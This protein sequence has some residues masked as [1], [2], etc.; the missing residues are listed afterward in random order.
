MPSSKILVNGHT[1]T[2]FDRELSWLAFSRRLLYAVADSHQPIL[3]RVKQL[4]QAS[5]SLDE[6]FMVKVP[7]LEAAAPACDQRQNHPQVCFQSIVQALVSRQQAHFADTL[8]PHLA[9]QGIHLQ[10]YATLTDIQKRQ[11]HHRFEDEIAPVLTTFI[12]P[13]GH[14]I[15]DFSNLSLNLAVWVADEDGDAIAWVKVPRSLSRFVLWPIP[16]QTANWVVIP[17]E[18]L[19]AAHLPQLLT[20]WRIRGVFP[21]RVTRSADSITL[22]APTDSWLEHVQQSLQARHQR[23]SAVRLEIT[24]TLPDWLCAELLSHLRLQAKAIY[25]LQGWLGLADLQEIAELPREDLQVVPWQPALP[26]AFK[27]RPIP[28]M[29][30]LGATGTVIHSDIFQL[31][32]T[33]DILL[34]FPYHSFTAT[35]ERFVTEAARDPAVLTIKM[36]LYRT[37]GDAPIVRSLMEAAKAGKQII[38]LV[39][40]TASLDEATNIHWAKSLEKAGAHVVYGV[41]GLKTHTNLILVIRQEADTLQQYAYVGTGDYLPDRLQPYEDLGYLTSCPTISADLCYLFNFLTG[42]SRQVAYQAL[43][44]APEGLR[45]QLKQII[46]AEIDQASQGQPAR[47]IVK[48]NQLADSDMIE[49]LYRASQAGVTI[50]L[51]V[52][53]V[54]C[55]R[56]GIP[57]LSDRIQV[58]SLLGR[59]VEHS[60][61]L[62]CHNGGQPKAWIGTADWT[63]RGLNERVEVM[64]PITA[65]ALI[66]DIE[67]R[68]QRWLMDTQQ[69]WQ[70]QPDGRYIRRQ[71]E[72]TEAPFSAQDIFMT[73]AKGTSTAPNN[74]R[75][76]FQSHQPFPAGRRGRGDK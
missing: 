54:C 59:Y 57:G 21:F 1:P 71:A 14:P 25:Q 32:A 58:T 19:V 45:T 55:L 35:V 23:S 10:D 28:S 75:S 48:L 70:L 43:M 39:E 76:S 52:R 63:P 49:T 67:Q 30:S 34:H 9:A 7:I 60:R 50:D 47:L 33:Q 37:A 31:L 29:L 11:L 65:P 53:G 44:V 3:Q 15:P 24:P 74:P 16:N 69:A 38:V 26:A 5:A 17:L 12:T 64:V 2:L 72:P 41:V 40:L 4:A 62:Y 6:Y 61:I 36:T 13:P 73:D 46:A 56:P 66:A 20:Q 68:L 51:I 22:N 42:C 27:A 8:R 18:Q